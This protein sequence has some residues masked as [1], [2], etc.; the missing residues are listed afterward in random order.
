LTRQSSNS[1]CDVEEILSDID[2]AVSD[3]TEKLQLPM[4]ANHPVPPSPSQTETSLKIAAFKKRAHELV[5]R[6]MKG[7]GEQKLSGESKEEEKSTL[8][9]KVDGT[10]GENKL[11]LTLYGNAPGPKQLFSSLQL[12]T[13]IAGETKDIVQTLRESGLPNGITTTQI[14]PIRSTG[15]NE[16]KRHVITLGELFPTPPAV[17]QLQ[18][19]KPSKIA[20]TRSSTVGWYQPATADP[21]PRSGSYF[22]QPIAGGQ[23]L[24][25][26]NASPSLGSKRKQRDR[27]LSLSATKAPQMDIETTEL[28]GAKLDILFRSAYS[29]FAPC[30]D[31]SVAIVPG[32]MM[33]RIWWQNIGERSFKRLVQNAN[34]LEDVM[35][36]HVDDTNMP[37]ADR[38]DEEE[39]FR[40]AVANFEGVVDPNLESIVEKAADEKDVDEVLEEIS[41]LLR[42]L[43]SHQRN[44]HLNLNP[45]G[46][47]GGLL[48]A[49]DTTSL[50]T[51]TKPGEPEISIYEI[52]KSQLT[53]MIATLPPYAVAKLDSDQLAEL[54][55]STKMEIRV[56]DHKGVM[57]EDEVSARAK[58]IAF[59][60]ASASRPV[61]PP[62]H[63]SS[64]SALYGNQYAA[65]R[66]AAPAPHQYYSQGQTPVRQPPNNLQRPP[67]TA[68]VPYPSQRPAGAPYRP[69]SFA[70]QSYQAPRPQQPYTPQPQYQ[71]APLP[72]YNRPASQPY[73]GVPQS[74]PPAASNPRYPGQP[75]FAQQTPGQN[76][77]DYRYGNGVNA[78]RQVSP[79]KPT[80]NPQPAYNQ[81]QS[82]PAYATP[83]PS[84]AQDRRPYL[85]NPMAPQMMNGG[86]T[87][88]HQSQNPPRPLGPTNYST[89]M[90]AEQQ[91][92]MMERQKAQLA[93]QQGLQQIARDTAQAGT[94]GSPSKSQVNGNAV[95]AGL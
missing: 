14:V 88:S 89:F 73:Q 85:Q 27:A 40:E 34:N 12:P 78:A 59:S 18:P 35:I 48:S 7:K 76:G 86:S 82:R 21:H 16:D 32:G 80:H 63:R 39:Q 83:T 47:A 93:Q 8:F 44:R 54:A 49:L 61:Q 33:D 84:V 74:A 69:N 70:T 75:Q 45:S 22:K 55:I 79:Q 51:P 13:K 4:A 25:Y 10:S 91:S 52:L 5:Q 60:A 64:S 77:I 81:G 87:P 19:P 71:Q 26:G 57:E 66:P 95:T 53:L 38:D 50:G 3:I 67:A 37:I 92:S 46:R 11:V 17:P 23:W 15:L 41:D 20:T 1:Y 90:T 6:E 62:Q 9:A 65:P 30:K 68:Q 56:E 94:M 2:L 29:S 58:A 31:D 72:N 43:N 24:D 36:P 42:T 28:E